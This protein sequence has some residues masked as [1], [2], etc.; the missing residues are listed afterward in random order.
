MILLRA[1]QIRGKKCTTPIQLHWKAE[2]VYLFNTFIHGNRFIQDDIGCRREGRIT[3]EKE[4]DE[5]N[6]TRT[7]SRVNVKRHARKRWSQEKRKG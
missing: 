2:I 1:C 5:K 6:T 7:E 3:K 4:I